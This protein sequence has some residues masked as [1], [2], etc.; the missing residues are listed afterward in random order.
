MAEVFNGT[1]EAEPYPLAPKV[2]LP[3]SVEGEI[4][5]GF[6]DAGRTASTFTPTTRNIGAEVG[7]PNVLF[8]KTFW[9]FRLVDSAVATEAEQ[10]MEVPD[11]DVGIISGPVIVK[12][13]AYN[14]A[15]EIATIASIDTESPLGVPF[16]PTGIALTGMVV[17]DAVD[18]Y[19]FLQY[20]H[21]IDPFGDQVLDVFYLYTAT[22]PSLPTSDGLQHL[23]GVRSTLLSQYPRPTGYGEI[24]LRATD[25]MIADDASEIR[26]A[27]LDEKSVRGVDYPAAL[28][29]EREI[30]ELYNFLRLGARAAVSVPR[31]FSEEEFTAAPAGAVLTVEDTTRGE[32]EVDGF[33]VI[34]DAC[35]A[36]NFAVRRVVALGAT[37]ITVSAPVVGFEEGDSVVPLIN[38][39]PDK[40]QLINLLDVDRGEARLTFIE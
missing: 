2:P 30:Q 11:Y 8:G 20:Q 27:L 4:T 21:E 6:I 36:F 3:L 28:V 29:N 13:I 39:F 19:D 31:W 22:Y 15:A 23:L 5:G 26:G 1:L 32:F 38:G 10:P 14:L 7:P 40:D 9:G 33:V 24:D 16:I 25:I 12:S 37:T 17:T 18:P 34:V 35:D